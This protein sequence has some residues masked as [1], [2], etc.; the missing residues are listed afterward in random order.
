MA[1]VSY[2]T[3]VMVREARRTSAIDDAP[4]LPRLLSFKLQELSK[5]L[6]LKAGQ[7]QET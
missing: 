2:L 3:C 7:T 4:Y 6:P 5:R 1:V